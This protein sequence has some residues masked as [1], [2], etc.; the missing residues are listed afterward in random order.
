MST[1]LVAEAGFSLRTK[2]SRK[3]GSPE[4]C[5]GADGPLDLNSVRHSSLW[6]W[7]APRPGK[8]VSHLMLWEQVARQSPK[9]FGCNPIWPLWG[10]AWVLTRSQESGGLARPRH[11]G[12]AGGV[13]HTLS[14]HS[15]I[16]SCLLHLAQRQHCNH[17]RGLLGLL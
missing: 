1:E 10:K 15:T 11:P 8:R 14:F 9:V 16:C 3:W 6:F 7:L 17:F 12:M 2:T 13:F 5:E 4:G